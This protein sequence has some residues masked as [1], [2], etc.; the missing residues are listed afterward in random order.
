[1]GNF[2]EFG[3]PS[4]A[5]ALRRLDALFE[6][7]Q[8]RMRGAMTAPDKEEFHTRPSRPPR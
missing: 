8:T 6:S 3:V 1:M 7:Q 5:V 2:A 4:A